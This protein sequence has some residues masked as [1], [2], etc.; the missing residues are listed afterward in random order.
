[1]KIV[2]EHKGFYGE[3]K[4]VHGGVVADG[5]IPTPEDLGSEDYQE[6]AKLMQGVLDLGGE[7]SGGNKTPRAIPR[8]DEVYKEHIDKLVEERNVMV[9]FLSR[10]AELL[11]QFSMCCGNPKIGEL[12]RDIEQAGFRE[13]VRFI[14]FTV[15]VAREKQEKMKDETYQG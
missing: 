14:K 2:I 6:F 4:R 5:A 9:E 10:S 7:V 11:Q 12:R 15:E 3:V 13:G 1:M 8:I